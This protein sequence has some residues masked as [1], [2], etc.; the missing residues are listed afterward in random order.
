ML[1]PWL[2][3]SVHVEVLFMEAPVCAVWEKTTGPGSKCQEFQGLPGHSLVSRSPDSFSTQSTDYHK[4]LFVS[5]APS[6]EG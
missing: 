4:S 1:C 2:V 3:D 6:E 5:Q